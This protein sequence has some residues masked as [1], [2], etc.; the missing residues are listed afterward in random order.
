MEEST[1]WMD[2]GELGKIKT[3]YKGGKGGWKGRVEK[4]VE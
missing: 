4:R 1:F 3:R 2:A